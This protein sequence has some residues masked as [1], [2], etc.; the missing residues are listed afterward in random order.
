MTLLHLAR[1]LRVRSSSEGNSAAVELPAVRGGE[2]GR[3][4]GRG[5][6]DGEREGGWREGG[7]MERG[8]GRGEGRE[9]RGREGRMDYIIIIHMHFMDFSI[10][11]CVR[12]YSTR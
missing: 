5:R 7:G 2:R 8:R 4:G 10:T 6:G 9:G 3:E 1:H 11:A 12:M